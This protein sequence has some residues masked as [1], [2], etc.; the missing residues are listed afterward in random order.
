MSS[1]ANK[2]LAIETA[3]ADLDKR[4]VDI[5]LDIGT[6]KEKYFKFRSTDDITQFLE[7]DSVA[8]STMKASKFYGSFQTRIDEWE[9]SLSVI[10]EVVESVL[11]V[12]RKWIYLESIFMSGGDIAKQLPSEYTLFV[13]VN[14]DFSK[15]MEGFSKNPVA[16]KCCLEQGIITIIIIILTIFIIF[17]IIILKGYLIEYLKWTKVSKRFKNV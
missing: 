10:S 5:E 16:T 4:W 11:G 3:L 14:N 9:H 7:D 15:E 12:Q 2:E 17:I 1:N 13:Q 8:L 6:Y